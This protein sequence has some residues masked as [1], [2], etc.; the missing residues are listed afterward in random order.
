MTSPQNAADVT[1][2]PRHERPIRLRASAGRG[3]A[4]TA[5]RRQSGARAR[6]TRGRR[7][8]RGRRSGR[9]RAHSS[10]SP[11]PGRTGPHR[12][13]P[14]A[15]RR[16]VCG[17]AHSQ[18]VAGLREQAL[19]ECGHVHP[20]GG[21]LRDEESGSV[22]IPVCMSSRSA[23]PEN[24]HSVLNVDTDRVTRTSRNGPSG[25]LSST[26]TAPA[27][28]ARAN[29]FE[30]TIARRSRPCVAATPSTSSPPR[31]G[32]SAAPRPPASPRRPPI[33]A[34]TAGASQAHARADDAAPVVAH[35][36]RHRSIHPTRRQ[37]DDAQQ[38]YDHTRPAHGPESVSPAGTE[39][40]LTRGL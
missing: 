4:G 37:H 31:R 14:A 39:P 28:S 13:A 35:A 7:R 32:H 34:F 2:I 11:A 22:A 38:G 8:A 1:T 3:G 33:A 27:S 6:R 40:R 15:T 36:H 9:S 10:S 29:P 5:A 24:D 18:R 26:T 19:I 21:E 16:E 20:F 12:E 30:R 17:H 25:P 23:T